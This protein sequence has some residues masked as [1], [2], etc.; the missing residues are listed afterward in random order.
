[1]FKTSTRYRFIICLLVLASCRNPT[2][3]KEEVREQPETP[4][5]VTGIS[6]EPME[7]YI[8]LNAVS[9]FLLKN[10]IKA[11]GNGYLQSAHAIPGQ[12]V[13]TG[14]IRFTIKTK[15]AESIGNAVNRL[16]TSFKFSGTNT[17]R[18]GTNGFISQLNHQS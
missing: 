8:E 17:I 12:F 9:A 11:N 4:V 18:S 6:T 15:E 1:M 2:S 14:Q 13:K 3:E 10:Y 7:E 5:T 16:D